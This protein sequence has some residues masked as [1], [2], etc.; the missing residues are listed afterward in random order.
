[1]FK[2]LGNKKIVVLLIS[3]IV[4]VALMGLTLMRT[5]MTTPEK[6]IKDTVTW[7]QGIFYRPAQQIAGFIQDIRDL[8]GLYEENRV[9]KATLSNY[10]KDTMRLNKL[11]SENKNLKELLEFTDRQKNL[12]NYKY[13]VA[14]VLSI[15]P[16]PYNGR[17][18]INLGSRDG[19]R[20]NMAVISTE[21]LV[22][23]VESVS[24]LS[25]SVQLLT[26][27]DATNNESKAISATVKGKER[28]FGIIQSY[29]PITQNLVM[30]NIEQTDELEVGD[31]V[32]TSGMGLVFPQG[33]EIGTVVAKE[34]GDFGINY[35]AQVEPVATFRHLSELLVVEVP[36][37]QDT[38]ID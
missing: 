15:S 11:E 3:L 36:N 1:M 10:A 27:L 32:I 22:G 9:L 35:V 13:H 30:T 16:D 4:F 21:G 34:D 19:I 14:Q 20:E 33:I 2:L 17:V 31:T 38:G 12:D 28:S 29:D 6:V 18:N 5:G 25:A 23:R 7:T 24:E 8:R 26:E 37:A